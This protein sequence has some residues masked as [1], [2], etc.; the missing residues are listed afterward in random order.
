MKKLLGIV[1]LGLLLS[2]NA[3][4]GSYKS[5][6]KNYFDM[7]VVAYGYDRKSFKNSN[8]KALMQCQ[9]YLN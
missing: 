1:V 8:Q 4:A 5:G 2:G 9:N 6:Y 3:Y 7:K